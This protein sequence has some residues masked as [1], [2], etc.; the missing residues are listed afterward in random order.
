MKRSKLSPLDDDALDPPIETLEK[1]FSLVGKTLSSDFKSTI[2]PSSPADGERRLEQLKRSLLGEGPRFLL[3]DTLGEGGMGR[4]FL[5]EQRGLGRKVAIKALRPEASEPRNIEKLLQEAW[6][7]GALEH[8]NIVPVHDIEL[9]SRGIPNVALKKIEG[10]HWGTYIHD[11]L[12]AERRLKVNDLLEWNLRILIQVCQAVHFAHVRGFIHR[13]LKPENVMIGEFG[14]V[15]VADWGLALAL[16]PD[17]RGRWPD[18]NGAV[19]IAGTPAYMAPEMLKASSDQLGPRTDVY[20]LGGILFEI[21]TGEAPHRGENFRELCRS[22]L[23]SPPVLPEGAPSELAAICTRAL[24]LEPD[25]RHPSAD[26]FR[27]DLESFLRHRGSRQ[28]AYRAERHLDRLAG[29][30]RSGRSDTREGVAQA[31]SLYTQCHYGFREAIRSWEGNRRAR[32]GLERAAALMIEWELARGA[33]EGAAGII[34]TLPEPPADLK[35]R[36]EIAAAE[37]QLKR[38]RFDALR[39]EHDPSRGRRTRF[40]FAALYGFLW[41]LMHLGVHFL[42]SDPIETHYAALGLMGAFLLLVAAT[43]LIV[44]DRLKT[45]HLNRTLALIVPFA[46]VASVVFWFGGSL[47]GLG[48]ET[49][50]ITTIFVWFIII[51]GLVITTERRFW[52]SS[53]TMLGAFFFSAYFPDLRHLAIAAANL[54]LTLNAIYLWRLPSDETAV[55]AAERQDL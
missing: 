10:E 15:Y 45:N 19:D 27:R 49:V 6:I 13:D 12:I 46:L 22:I 54:S 48:P 21:L 47:L 40:F 24:A 42:G 32:A 26:E 7:T 20:L 14:E 11:A 30:L 44:E 5:A 17:P 51:G 43:G 3:E 8:P 2:S 55:D 33:T 18:I 4:V 41:T 53:L 37:E 31:Y 34:A 25:Q 38:E 35:R 1:K 39:E 29:L 9:D 23:S 52:P 16:R 36:V 28:I 50:Q